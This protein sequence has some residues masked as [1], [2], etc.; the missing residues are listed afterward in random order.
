MESVCHLWKIVNLQVEKVF[1]HYY[2]QDE[3]CQRCYSQCVLRVLQATFVHQLN[4]KEEFVWQS[5][6]L[7]GAVCLHGKVGCQKKDLVWQIFC[8]LEMICPQ[9]SMHLQEHVVWQSF[10]LLEAMYL[11]WKVGLQK[12]D[13]VWRILPVLEVMYL[14]GSVGIQK[15]DLVWQRFHLLEAGH[16]QV[17]KVFLAHQLE[18]VVC[19]QG[20]QHEVLLCRKFHLLVDWIQVDLIQMK[21]VLVWSVQ[22]LYK[23]RTHR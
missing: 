12:G 17:G 18:G 4:Q 23:S 9:G 20:N 11:P 13:L 10:H 7:L 14:L 8:L 19:F 1:L 3:E 15:E 16:L 2:Q 6:H 22:G 5:C 21:M